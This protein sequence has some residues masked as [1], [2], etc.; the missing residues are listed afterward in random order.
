MGEISMARVLDIMQR[1]AIS[2]IERHNEIAK[3]LADTAGEGAGKIYE[4]RIQDVPV[5]VRNDLST[6]DKI[7][8]NNKSYYID[9]FKMGSKTYKEMYNSEG[10]LVRRMVDGK[11]VEL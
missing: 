4:A 7:T 8:L 6:T 9:E 10:V 2:K 1:S 11:E 5:F 3:Y